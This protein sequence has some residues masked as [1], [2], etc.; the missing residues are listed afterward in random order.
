MFVPSVESVRILAMDHD[1]GGADRGP[2]LRA[3]GT[4]AQRSV[5]LLRECGFRRFEITPGPVLSE[6]QIFE[7]RIRLINALR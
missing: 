3:A 1:Q 2:F 5:A 7:E 6:L 4:D